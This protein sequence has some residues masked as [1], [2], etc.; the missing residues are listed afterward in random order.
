MP[1]YDDSEIIALPPH[2]V[3]HFISV[4]KHSRRTVCLADSGGEEVNSGNLMK[5][6]IEDGLSSQGCEEYD[7]H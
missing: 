6:L 2:F 1:A 3:M 5:I 7:K 4:S